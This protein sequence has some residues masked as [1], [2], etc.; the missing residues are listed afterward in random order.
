MPAITVSLDGVELAT[1]CTDGHE[2]LSVRVSGT[3]CSG[4]LASLDVGGSLQSGGEGFTSLLWI[5]KRPLDT[6]QKLEV[7][8]AQAG[9]TTLQARN[10][11]DLYPAD[12]VLDAEVKALLGSGPSEAMMRKL[13]ARPWRRG[14]Y[15]L[16]YASSSGLAYAGSTQVDD[17]SVGLNVLWHRA[18]PG[19]M[20]VS[21]TSSTIDSIEDKAPLRTHVEEF[22][23]VGQS[24]VLAIGATAA[25]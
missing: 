17:Y 22:L 24:F 20:R 10:F 18:H 7:T 2:M 5:D 13:R 21:L 19:H 9:A 11:R 1:V 6:G 12:P 4:I 16:E 14:P 8:F 23:E 25:V 3:R 15:G